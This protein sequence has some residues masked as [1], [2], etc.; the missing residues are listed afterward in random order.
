MEKSPVL[1]AVV[2]GEW[3][4][5]SERS[6]RWEEWD[7]ATVSMFVEWLYTGEYCCVYPVFVS[8]PGLR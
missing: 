4:E 7:S 3:K 1:E 2:N 8:K 6:I 5:S